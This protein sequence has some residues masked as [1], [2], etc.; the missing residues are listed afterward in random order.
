MKGLLKNNMYAAISNIK[1]F[2]V[3]MVLGGFFITVVIR[4]DLLNILIINSNFAH[5]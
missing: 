1:F 3:V 5:E 2:L 4:P